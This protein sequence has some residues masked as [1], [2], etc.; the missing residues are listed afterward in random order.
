MKLPDIPASKVIPLDG[1]LAIARGGEI[2]EFIVYY[3]ASVEQRG[4]VFP[5]RK[6]VKG[7][8]VVK[9]LITG[10]TDGD[11]LKTV[12]DIRRIIRME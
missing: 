10:P 5:F 9:S 1:T 2:G 7:K 8:D 3:G 4:D 12:T 6:V 11:R